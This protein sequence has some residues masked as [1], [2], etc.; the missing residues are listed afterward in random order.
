M[1]SGRQR[2]GPARR[3]HRHAHHVRVSTVVRDGGV[4]RS[5]ASWPDIRRRQDLL[6]AD[7][8][9]LGRAQYRAPRRAHHHQVPATPMSCLTPRCGRPQCAKSGHSPAAWRTAQINLKQSFEAESRR[10]ESTAGVTR[11]GLRSA[12]LQTR[13]SQSI[14]HM[15]KLFQVSLG[16]IELPLRCDNLL[17]GQSRKKA[18]SSVNFLV[19]RI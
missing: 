6:R 12:L 8:G 4:G 14:D 3:A 11:A 10:P 17:D 5:P 1:R 9:L 13:Q 15:I 16:G 2:R 18:N 7:C 19:R